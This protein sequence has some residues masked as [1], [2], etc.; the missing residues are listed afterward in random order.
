MNALAGIILGVSFAI[1]AIVV[2]I[3]S[4]ALLI[5]AFH[6]PQYGGGHAIAASILIGSTVI[7]LAIA[8]RRESD[9]R[10]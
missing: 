6:N 1:Y 7:A 3:L 2:L 8:T 9:H 10:E 4:I 5:E